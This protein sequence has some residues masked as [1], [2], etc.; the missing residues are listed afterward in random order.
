MPLSHRSVLNHVV[1]RNIALSA[2][3]ACCVDSR[4]RHEDVSSPPYAAETGSSSYGPTVRF[5]LLPTPS[6]DDAVTFSYGAVAAPDRDL[7]PASSMP[8]RAYILRQS[9]RYSDCYPLKGG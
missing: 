9:R 8:S 3:A 6:H 1:G 4:L 2:T 5:R 7:H